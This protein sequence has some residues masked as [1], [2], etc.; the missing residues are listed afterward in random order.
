MIHRGS[1]GL[2]FQT[3]ELPR[4]F[5]SWATNLYLRFMLSVIHPDG[6]KRFRQHGERLL[7]RML[8]MEREDL[9][10]WK[11]ARASSGLRANPRTDQ[12]QS[13]VQSSAPLSFE[14]GMNS[15]QAGRTV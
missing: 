10:A 11:T 3:F 12:P 13:S 6:G 2:G 8:V 4:G 5:F 1:E 14:P 15:D 9:L 7:P